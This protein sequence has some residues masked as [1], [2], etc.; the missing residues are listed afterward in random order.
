MVELNFLGAP[1]NQVTN[2]KG[3][4]LMKSQGYQLI[5]T[6][7]TKYLDLAVRCAASIKYWDPK[8]RIQLLTDVEPEL[9][10]QYKGLFDDITPYAN[11]TEFLGPMI[12]LQMYDYAIYDET[13]FI[14]ADCLILKGD[15]DSYWERLSRSY[16]VTVPGKWS[17]DGEWYGMQISE[18]CE[19]ANVAKLVK[20]NSGVLYFK[21]GSVAES[22][23]NT[24]KELFRRL[25]NFANHIHRGLGPADEPY[26][27]L[28]FGVEALN[29][30]PVL[31]EKGNAWM[32]S[33]IGSSEHNLDAFSGKP[34]FVKGGELSPTVSHFIGLSPLPVYEKL[35][36]QFLDEAN[37]NSK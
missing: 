11:S 24:A 33:T 13:M 3:H 32:V 26:L 34:T 31:D 4:T 15:M 25:G 7:P 27:A 18:M 19:L 28:A 10:A 36:K 17:S 29:P 14:D 21:H 20:M 22:F 30:F 16:E 9:I 2:I 1:N 5:A 23:F 35:C 8:R 12:K 6:G 37:I